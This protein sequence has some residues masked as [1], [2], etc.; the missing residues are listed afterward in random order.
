MQ[1][2]TILWADDEID[3]LKPHII[4]LQNKGYEVIPVFSGNEAIEKCL[5]PTIDV[6]F[7][8]E[9]MPGITG[10]ETLEQVKQIRPT[11]PVV[12]ITK[13]DEERIMEQAIGSKI[14]DYLLKPINPNQIIIALKKILD[15]RRLVTEKTNQSYQQ[16]FRNIS[17][18]F[19]DNLDFNEWSDVYK[20]LIY[21]DLELEKSEDSSMS[22]I[23]ENQKT[24]ANSLFCKYITENYE[25]WLNNSKIER[26]L[27]SHQLFKKK[28]LP[29][30][31]ENEC[32]FFFLIDNLRFDQWRI[33]RPI[34]EE[35]YSVIEESTFFSIL[36]TTTA[37]SRNSIFAGMMPAE[38][39]KKYPNLWVNDDDE[40][41]Q[42]LHEEE[43]LSNQLKN[44]KCDYKFS[45]HKIVNI[46]QGKTLTEQYNNLLGNKLNVVVYNFVDMLSHARTDMNMIRELASTES[47]YRSITK[48]WFEH[49]PFYELL[50][51]L[52]T[53]KVK[54]I[55]ATDHGTVFV[56]K[57]H[58]VIGDKETTNDN[59]RYKQGKNLTFD[60][61]GIYF[62]RK[63]ERL[64]LPKRNI[65]TTF[66]FCTEDKFF[67]YPNN[68]NYYVSYYKNTFQH[69]GISLE[70]I[71]IPY[72]LAEPKV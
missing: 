45:Y 6:L 2:H 27:L 21:W 62:T 10:L 7:L 30:V 46:S 61:K 41:G 13:N 57:A 31:A 29:V 33:L 36:P 44:N 69:G 40:E 3:L 59:L 67:A 47:A 28:V 55:F 58:K 19:N 16:D 5:D 32:T 17:L 20:K 38:I 70:E 12:M 24:E 53:K 18:S 14:A 65:S 66:A 51:N 43:L 26:P 49:S 4:F 39:E 48:S 25:E 64:L 54:V 71:I 15:N 11:L 9:N 52:A 42:N 50:K 23:L 35:M 63:P 60:E 68:F 34:I 37:Y 22:E 72:V 56:K 1:K 8:D